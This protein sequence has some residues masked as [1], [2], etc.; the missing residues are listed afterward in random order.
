MYKPVSIQR[1]F[2][3]ASG[4]PTPIVVDLFGESTIT[5][6]NKYRTQLS[7]TKVDKSKGGV[8]GQNSL[9]TPVQ[10]TTRICALNL[11]PIIIIG[12]RR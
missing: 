4:T 2:V 6:V 8:Q 12:L 7:D 10:F 5:V 11:R 9:F 3:F 1:S